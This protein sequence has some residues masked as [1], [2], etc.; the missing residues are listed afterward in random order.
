MANI[1]SCFVAALTFAKMLQESPSSPPYLVTISADIIN[2]LREREMDLF[3]RSHSVMHIQ[4]IAVKI[5]LT[6]EEAIQGE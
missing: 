6:E 4:N 2:Y 1:L 5:G 3:G